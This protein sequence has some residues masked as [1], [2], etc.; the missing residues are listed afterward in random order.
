MRNNW[1]IRIVYSAASF[2]KCTWIMRREPRSTLLGAKLYSIRIDKVRYSASCLRCCIH[3]P[4]SDI[5]RF[6]ANSTTRHIYPFPSL[7]S[8]M[9]ENGWNVAHF[10]QGSLQARSLL[11]QS[12]DDAEVTFC[13][14]RFLEVKSFDIQN[15]SLSRIYA[16]TQPQSQISI[17]PQ[18]ASP[19]L[20]LIPLHSRKRMA[21]RLAGV[22]RQSNRIVVLLPPRLS[23]FLPCISF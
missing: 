12:L 21:G 16:S 9:S 5:I 19:M 15:K 10:P 13:F 2:A 6:H 17:L 4:F 8:L 20:I 18:M 1:N 7:C 23:F 22:L 3:S 11:R 14:W